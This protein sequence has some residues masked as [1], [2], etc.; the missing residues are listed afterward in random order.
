MKGLTPL[1]SHY[2]LHIRCTCMR[3]LIFILVFYCCT[4]LSAQQLTSNTELYKSSESAST[5]E[6]LLDNLQNRFK[7]RFSYSSTLLDVKEILVWQDS[8]A[9]FEELLSSTY[10]KYKFEIESQISGKVLI[11]TKGK[12]QLSLS[13]F[14]RD[15]QS[16]ELLPGAMIYCNVGN[17]VTFVDDEG[18]YF[19][20]IP[21]TA[22]T[23]FARSLGYEEM[24]YPLSHFD[25]HRK[26]FLMSFENNFVPVVIKE[27]LQD[28]ILSDPHSEQVVFKRFQQSKGVLGDNDLLHNVRSMPGTVAG[29]EGQIGLLVQGGSA[30]Q[31]L[32]LLDGMPLYE[33][34][35]VG[36]LSSVFIE[37]TVRSADFIKTGM[38]ARY[39]GR[40][41]SVLNVTLKDGNVSSSS[42]S[43][44]VGLTGGRFA[45]EGPI[46]SKGKTTFNL[47]G[48]FSWINAG[49]DL[50]QKYITLYD[51]VDVRY[52]DAVAKITHRPTTSSKISLSAY[53]GG[54]R[55]T[56]LKENEG[57]IN[58]PVSQIR[59]RELN[60]LGWSNKL[61]SANYDQLIFN[62]TKISA[63][64]GVLDYKHESRGQYTSD[65]LFTVDT[66]ESVVDVISYS[67]IRDYQ[68]SLSV[69]HYFSDDIRLQAGSKMILHRFN[70][71]ARQNL[72][73]T[74]DEIDAFVDP[75]SAFYAREYNYYVEARMGLG[76]DFTFYPGVSATVFDFGDGSY[77]VVQPRALLVYTID[78]QFILS[79]AYS[80][81]V[82]FSHLLSN[83][84]L[85]LPS[86]LWVPSSEEVPPEIARSISINARRSLPLD[87]TLE[88]SWYNKYYSNLID[89]SL[90]VDLFV[91]LVDPENSALPVLTS[92]NSWLQNI[93]IGTGRS[94]GVDVSLSREVGRVKSRVNLGYSRSFREFEDISDGEEY[95]A[96]YDIPLN[97]T[98]V[99]T[100]EHSDDWQFGLNWSY[101]SGAPF[102]LSIEEFDSPLGVKLLAPDGRNNYRL[103]AYH[104]L[105]LTGAYLWKGRS[106]SEYSL[107]FGVYNVYNRLNPFYIYASR[108]ELTGSKL[109]LK[110][111][112]L[113]PILP[114]VSF[115]AAW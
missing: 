31:N 70:P 85:G 29:S 2:V 56:L 33:V 65:F 66:I 97:I 53:S 46:G 51:D 35:H 101:A 103:P 28:L 95:R 1:L 72:I 50:M 80:E 55:V 34:S 5:V 19:F 40:L 78:D 43:I 76:D 75:D 86:D 105:S 71:T 84:G 11:I 109:E 49:I 23:V 99:A 100:Y 58:D 61:L 47:G 21:I 106:E 90:P 54:D 69:K 108:D 16:G 38:P 87:I 93:K 42:N 79:G 52:N 39:N 60:Q 25:S 94:Y 26:D 15:A 63:Q 92:H 77:R 91:N 32:I 74:G 37:E 6:Q 82:Q 48:R 104:Q 12:T 112:S 57:N 10:P 8:V 17:L 41:S 7:V 114:H 89:Y 13:G 44:N 18:Y 14:V 115:H 4:A 20:D 111:V 45:A 62:K 83:P 24:A 59:N 3:I 102:S 73:E 113:F 68:A 30:D 27:T 9:T 22:D 36:G 67:G 107:D 64:L 96:L 81:S 88:A 98:A 110:K